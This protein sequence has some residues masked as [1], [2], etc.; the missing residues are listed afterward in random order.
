VTAAE[1][2]RKSAQASLEEAPEEDILIYLLEDLWDQL[3][4]ARRSSMS[5]EW[6]IK[7][8]GIVH[9]ITWLTKHIQKPIGWKSVP[10]QLTLDGT[11]EAIHEGIGTPTPLNDEARAQAQAH[12][13]T[14]IAPKRPRQAR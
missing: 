14:Y 1:E 2:A 13:D 3:A 4:E 12:Y 7:C 9:R 8:D 5:G 10:I 11:Y 6:S